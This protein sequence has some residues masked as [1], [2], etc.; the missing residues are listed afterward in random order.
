MELTFQ[1]KALNC[2]RTAKQDVR[3]EELTQEVR[4]AESM[5]DVGRVLSAWA[6][7]LLRSKQWS[8][9]DISLSGG[10][11]VW[12]LYLPE[13]GGGVQTVETWIPFQM[14]WD[15]PDTQRDGT[16]RTACRIQSVDARSTSPRK[17]MAR[18][19][20]SVWTEALEPVTASVPQMQALPEDVQVLR[21]TYPLRLAL[22]AGEKPFLMDEALE[23][24]GSCPAMEKLLRYELQPEL[25][26]KKIMANKVVFRGT[27]VLHIL[28]LGE[29]GGLKT[30]DFELPFSQYADL[31]GEY[32][33]N[34]ECNLT[35]ALTSLELDR[36]S[37]NRLGLKAGIT[38]QYVIYDT[39]M[40]DVIQDAYSPRRSVTVK[41]Q[42]VQ[43]PMVLDM[44]RE[45]RHIQQS[46]E[47]S[48]MQSIDTGLSMGHCSV[49]RQTDGVKI[50]QSGAF[51]TLYYDDE[52][53]LQSALS[54]WEDSYDMNAGEDTQTSAM[55]L[56]AGRPSS[57][58]AGGRLECQADV[59]MELMTLGG[60]GMEMVTGL[61]LGELSEPDPGRP[62]LV[63]RRAG[64]QS[65]W[66]LAKGCGST[67]DAICQANNLTG[68]PK[69]DQILLIPIA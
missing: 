21:R 67:V 32:G 7:P 53:Q 65:L 6:Q 55:T 3:S 64:K 10:V 31:E 37:G 8:G 46:Q 30:W 20:L 39:Q 62:A 36:E 42:E 35:L 19:V 14:R 22:E 48:A 17:L 66:E 63:L 60:S 29:D 58:A 51:Q 26:D 33:Q 11:M 27:G 34:G 25:L 16:I 12:V 68:E 28:Y 59:A 50:E 24:P 44:R 54:R 47:R 2:L 38:G 15:L 41:R 13:D 1:N 43:L 40:T 57:A 52:G 4:L 56:C 69:Q 23:L 5:P 61:E 49:R 18:C 9:S 45:L